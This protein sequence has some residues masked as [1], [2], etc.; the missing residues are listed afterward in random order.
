MENEYKIVY[1][2]RTEGAIEESLTIREEDIKATINILIN[3]DYQV[4]SMRL[5]SRA[6]ELFG[7][8][9]NG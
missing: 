2:S 9:K 8:N 4:L 7:E 3:N 1:K 6:E 5:L